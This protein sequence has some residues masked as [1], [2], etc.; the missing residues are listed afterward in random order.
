MQNERESGERVMAGEYWKH[1]EI[2]TKLTSPSPCP[3]LCESMLSPYKLSNYRYIPARK[4]FALKGNSIQH[5]PH[6]SDYQAAGRCP[7]QK[8]SL[9]KNGARIFRGTL[10]WL[11][12]DCGTVSTAAAKRGK[13]SSLRYIFKHLK[14]KHIRGIIPPLLTAANRSKRIS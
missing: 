5:C 12:R 8:W 7:F 14:K 4:A 9:K 11:G 2:S 3:S 1:G 10:L 6:W 13:Q